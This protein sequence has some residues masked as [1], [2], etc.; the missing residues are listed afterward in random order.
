[1]NK[2]TT[3]DYAYCLSKRWTPA[4][5]ACYLTG[6]DACTPGLIKTIAHIQKINNDNAQRLLESV[7]TWS[8]DKPRIFFIAY[9]NSVM[10]FWYI[11][12][13]IREGLSISKELLKSVNIKFNR[14]N[15]MDQKKF[16]EYPY[17]LKE[18]EQSFAP[19]KSKTNDELRQEIFQELSNNPAYSNSTLFNTGTKHFERNKMILF[20]AV[21]IFMHDKSTKMEAIATQLSKTKETSIE[22]QAFK[23]LIRKALLLEFVSLMEEKINII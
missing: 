21:D 7:M 9:N 10:P 1:M 16:E 12:I 5:A 11:N 23:Q 18:I 15:T 17:L 2:E 22:Y 20:S 6:L 14:Y 4:E 13:A 3:F 8:T 19:E